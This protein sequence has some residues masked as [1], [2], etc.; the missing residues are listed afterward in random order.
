MRKG[1]AKKKTGSTEELLN[2]SPEVLDPAR[3]SVLS[4]ASLNPASLAQGWSVHHRGTGM[5]W[6]PPAEESSSLWGA[7]ITPIETT[8]TLKQGVAAS[9]PIDQRPKSKSRITGSVGKVGPF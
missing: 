2:G 8:K 5:G 3:L 1:I 6:T 4:N 7:K 9:A